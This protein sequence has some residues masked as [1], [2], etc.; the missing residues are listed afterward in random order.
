[1]CGD[2]K[3]CLLSSAEVLLEDILLLSQGESRFRFPLY[4]KYFF[5]VHTVYTGRDVINATCMTAAR[6]HEH[7]AERQVHNAQLQ[8]CESVL[9]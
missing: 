1:M 6:L 7:V 4:R 3:L 9:V 2:I 5:Q 8:S